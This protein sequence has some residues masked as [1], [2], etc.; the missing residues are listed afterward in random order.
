MGVHASLHQLAEC[1]FQLSKV[2]EPL[3]NIQQMAFTDG[4]D[5]V[6]MLRGVFGQVEKGANVA[7]R[8]AKIAAATNEAQPTYRRCIIEPSPI[9]AAIGG[10]D[11][12]FSL[13]VANGLD[14]HA[15]QFGRLS[16]GPQISP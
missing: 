15:A 8:K 11:D 1:Y 2:G 12:P 7:D 5:I 13:I 9:C 6:A 4:A 14:I 10:R 16:N 3:T